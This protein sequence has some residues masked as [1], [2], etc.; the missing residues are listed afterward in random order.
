VE[1][2]AQASIANRKRLIVQA[3]RNALM[4][5]STGV[6]AAK[7]SGETFYTLYSRITA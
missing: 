7:K 3:L 4:N 1:L 5:L 6:F 2:A